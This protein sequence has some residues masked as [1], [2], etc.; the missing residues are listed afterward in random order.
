ML[1]LK[2]FR[3]HFKISQK[4]LA[5]SFGSLERLGFG[6]T[7]GRFFLNLNIVNIKYFILEFGFNPLKN[8]KKIFFYYDPKS[9]FHLKC[10][11]VFNLKDVVT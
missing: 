7:A 9:S 10:L 6:D 4:Y 1:R 3:K 11:N 2:I 5:L 8:L